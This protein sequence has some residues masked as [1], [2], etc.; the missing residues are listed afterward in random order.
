MF[1]IWPDTS[2]KSGAR[3]GVISGYVALGWVALGHLYD[4]FGTYAIMNYWRTT[5]AK[6]PPLDFGTF[7]AGNTLAEFSLG[8]CIAALIC[9]LLA[10]KFKRII[11]GIGLVWTCLQLGILALFFNSSLVF[12]VMVPIRLL[13]AING[14][15]GA[16]AFHVT[17]DKQG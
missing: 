2:T 15:R 5:A 12:W 14:V 4:L 8:A 17:P 16:S 3:A 9:M 13:L 7:I 11:F 10:S 6:L 1:F